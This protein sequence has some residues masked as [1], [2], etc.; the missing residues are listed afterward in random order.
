MLQLLESLSDLEPLFVEFYHV[1]IVLQTDYVETKRTEVFL[2][3]VSALVVC[4]LQLTF[5]VLE[6][7]IH[8]QVLEKTAVSDLPHEGVLDV[9]I[10]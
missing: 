3:L 8:L 2:L 1:E 10:C 9:H 5:H 7:E 4:F 6:I